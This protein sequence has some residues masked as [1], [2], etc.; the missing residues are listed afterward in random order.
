MKKI[1]K[2]E[3]KIKYISNY[4]IKNVTENRKKDTYNVQYIIKIYGTVQGVGFR[5]F[6]YNKA[7]D[8]KIYG[9]VKNVGGAVVIDCRGKRDN[10]K[11][12][13]LDIVKNSPSLA[14]IEKIECVFIKNKL[15]LYRNAKNGHFII[16]ESDNEKN[17]IRFISHDV[18]VCPKCL[19]DIKEKGT[20]RYKYAFTNCTECGPRYSIVKD[21]PYDR[22][23]TTMDTFTMCED[24]KKEY[25]NPLS[26]RFHAETNCCEKCGPKLFL[27][28]NKGKEIQCGDVIE[29]TIKLLEEGKILA[30]KG[31]G[32]FHLVCDGRNEEAIKL[33][34]NKKHRRDKPLALMAKDINVVKEICFISNKEEDLLKSNKRPIVILKKKY[35]YSLPEAI[36][37][38]QNYLGIMLP[39]TPLHYLLFNK[40]LNLLIMTSG[41]VSRR[42]ME[43]KN[44]ESIKHLSKACDYFLVHDREI[45]NPEDDSVVKIINGMERVIRRGRGYT[46]YAV[47]IKTDNFSQFILILNYKTQKT[48]LNK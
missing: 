27:I 35:P 21:L 25:D 16:Q 7:K 12:F 8:F 1:A 4:K 23:Q 5:P 43:Y 22:K 41:N 18:A 36:A 38:N 13:I 2:E 33:L 6:V 17:Q 31:I 42:T 9:Y 47:K 46:P 19:E 26:R 20:S 30:I 11:H 28:D 24:C 34:R 15:T 29:E 37:Q 39:Y 3:H 10:I 40:D 14:N 45:Y 32:G 48:P 44:D